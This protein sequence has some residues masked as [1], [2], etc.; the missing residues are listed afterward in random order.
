MGRLL[1]TRPCHS[2][3]HHSILGSHTPN[4]GKR[5]QEKW[6]LWHVVQ[7]KAGEVYRSSLSISCLREGSDT[8]FWPFC[9]FSGFPS[10]LLSGHRWPSVN[11]NTTWFILSLNGSN[12]KTH[13]EN[14]SWSN[15]NVSRLIILVDKFSRNK[16]SP[17]CVTSVYE[18]LEHHADS[19][20][21]A[22]MGVILSISQFPTIPALV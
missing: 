5:G 7:K 15:L 6:L 16:S 12:F 13:N 17:Q 3:C 10:Q 21:Q 19:Y 4:E 2:G 14:Q 8:P 1:Q 22:S 18:R 20:L 11:H 9:E